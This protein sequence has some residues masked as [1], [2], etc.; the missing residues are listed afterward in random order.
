MSDNWD[1]HDEEVAAGASCPVRE[2]GALA[3]VYDSS[4]CA[5]ADVSGPWEFR[6]PYCGVDFTALAD[7]LIFQSVPRKWLL[8]RVQA[9]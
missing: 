1:K 3:V 8:A 9:A 6:C 4:D 5:G 7:E 2:C